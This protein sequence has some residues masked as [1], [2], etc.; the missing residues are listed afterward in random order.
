MLFAARGI[1]AVTLWSI[2]SLWALQLSYGV[3]GHLVT[4]ALQSGFLAGM[5]GLTYGVAR[6]AQRT[7]QRLVRQRDDLDHRLHRLEEQ[8]E[9]ERAV[10]RIG[11]GVARLAHGLKN[12]VHSLRGFVSLIEPTVGDRSDAAAALAGLRTAIDDL[13][14]LARL[15]LEQGEEKA[16]LPVDR[17]FSGQVV[18]RAVRE[19]QVAD[20]GVT[21]RIDDRAPGAEPAIGADELQE[22]LLILLRNAVEAMR[23]SGRG[24]VEVRRSADTLHILV[25][26]E[27]PGIAESE[28][29]EIFKPGY[30]TKPEGS[31]YGL[32]LAHRIL[33]DA[34]GSLA[35]RAGEAGGAVLE[36]ALPLARR[37]DAGP[38]A[39]G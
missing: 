15:T 30:T 6:N 22:V 12:A 20:A 34:R 39:R 32:F 26:D 38:G 19:V 37:A 33:S 29:A 18:D 16:P 1:A 24:S 9:S 8:L 14:A 7:E 4:L 21:W 13:E 35:A 28:I 27:G 31:G 36:I 10:G 3:G 23:G 17:C 25:S 11:E 5:G 2:A